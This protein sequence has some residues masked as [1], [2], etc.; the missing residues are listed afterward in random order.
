MSVIK[1]K[2]FK[3]SSRIDNL[4]PSGLT[5]GEP[6]ITEAAYNG[7]FKVGDGEYILSYTERSEGGRIATDITVAKDTVRVKRVGAVACDMYFEEKVT[8]RSVYGVSPYSFD[9]EVTAK[10]IRNLVNGDGGT[11][12]LVYLMRIGGAE[13]HVRMKIEISDADGKLR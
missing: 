7:Y 4:L 11:A 9:A 8:H 2:K 10:R 3:I 12:E 6:E 13:K 1:E 5:D